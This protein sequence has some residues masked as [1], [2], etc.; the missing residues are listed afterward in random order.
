MAGSDRDIPD[1][2]KPGSAERRRSLLRR[3]EP[4]PVTEAMVTPRT[5]PTGSQDPPPMTIRF[6]PSCGIRTE[7]GHSYC[8][9]C[10]M[11]FGSGVRTGATPASRPQ[12]PVR[13]QGDEQPV[14][15]VTERPA[16]GF[17]PSG[18]NEP[19]EGSEELAP[20]VSGGRRALRSLLVIILVIAVLVVG[21]GTLR[22]GDE[23]PPAPP[24]ET[25]PT[26]TEAVDAP[27]FRDYAEQVAVLA[28]D[29]A[30]LRVSGRQIN[31]DWDDRIADYDTTVERM[32]SLI[33]RAGLL[34]IR[35]NGFTRPL[36]ADRL[37]HERMRESLEALVSAADGMMA[38]LQT[39]DT[40]Q[41]RLAQLARFEAAATEFGSLAEGV[42]QA[43][44]GPSSGSGG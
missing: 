36:D 39:A 30:D 34:P 42:E 14:A 29:V 28:D 43:A 19:E 20:S 21:F 40:G 8:L 41:V 4:T 37:T 38:G 2:E 32:S 18:W 7:P 1:D 15:G 33:S 44:A 27:G 23:P 35:F 22:S 12:D 6:C 31:D 16:S 26:T 5:R 10:G 24:E 9:A 11:R 3:V 13:A 25:S 17:P